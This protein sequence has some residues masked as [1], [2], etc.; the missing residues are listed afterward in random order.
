M[1]RE[2]NMHFH[3]SRCVFSKTKTGKFRF[4]VKLCPDYIGETVKLFCTVE[5]NLA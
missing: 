2:K 5:L 4:F 1:L 3:C